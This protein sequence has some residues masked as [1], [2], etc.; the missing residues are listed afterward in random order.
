[1]SGFI[2]SIGKVGS[3]AS[4]VA[5]GT[6]AV[7]QIGSAVTFTG[8]LSDFNL[9]SAQ[10]KTLRE[11]NAISY[12]SKGEAIIKA[13]DIEKAGGDLSGLDL[14]KA[15]AYIRTNAASSNPVVNQDSG[16]V[17]KAAS[18]LL[19]KGNTGSNEVSL[20]KAASNVEESENIQ[21]FNIGSLA[22]SSAANVGMS[23]LNLNPAAADVN[24]G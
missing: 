9:T 19:G 1:M 3:V 4:A 12:N 8:K 18:K 6:V 7:G 5:R 22:E 24:N 15:E 21:G 14:T 11:Q 20:A 13:I 2:T 16:N 23:P 17:G 10:L